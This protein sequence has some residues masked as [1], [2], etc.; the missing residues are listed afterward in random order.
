[1]CFLQ[2]ITGTLEIPLLSTEEVR[3]LTLAVKCE[4]NISAKNNRFF[5]KLQLT[6]VETSVYLVK[7]GANVSANE[8][9]TLWIA[10]KYGHQDIIFYLIESGANPRVSQ[11]LRLLRLLRF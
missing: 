6:V 8:E 11:I 1:M 7:R 4:A 5:V 9:E 3:I 2:R 10:A